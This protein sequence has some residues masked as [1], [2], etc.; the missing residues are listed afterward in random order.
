MNYVLG[1][2]IRRSGTD[3]AEVAL[4]V[5]NRPHWQAGKLNGIGGKIEWAD[6]QELA[7]RTGTLYT[8]VGPAIAQIAMV[9]EFREETGVDTVESDWRHFG[10]LNHCGALIYLFVSFG[11]AALRSLTDE[12]VLW[13]P[14][15]ELHAWRAMPNLAWLVPMA[16]DKSNVVAEIVDNSPIPAKPAETAVA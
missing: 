8:E 16:M 15:D 5:K 14:V 4:I 10:T 12:P 7:A 11:Q 13:V 3:A 6:H 2:R 9:R 1:F